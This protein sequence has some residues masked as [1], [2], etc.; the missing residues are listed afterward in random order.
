MSHAYSPE[1]S[2]IALLGFVVV[3]L[4]TSQSFTILLIMSPRPQSPTQPCGQNTNQ[5]FSKNVHETTSVEQESASWFGDEHEESPKADDKLHG[6]PARSA[7]QNIGGSVLSLLVGLLPIYF[8]VFA[9][10]GHDSDGARLLS[11]SQAEWLLK[12]A[13]YVSIATGHLECAFQLTQACQGPTVYPIVFAGIVGSLMTAIASWRLERSISIG[14]LEYLLSSR[15]VGSALLSLLRLRILNTWI[16]LVLMAWCLSPLAGQASLRV[17]DSQLHPRTSTSVVSYLAVN[18]TIITTPNS[19]NYQASTAAAFMTYLTSPS[20]SKNGSQDIYGN[21]QIPMAEAL[22]NAD[23]DDD[24]STV[25]P[26]MQKSAMAGIPLQGIVTGVNSSFGFETSYMSLNCNVNIIPLPQGRDFETAD[27]WYVT[28]TKLGALAGTD[29]VYKPTDGGSGL[30]LIDWNPDHVAISPTPRTIVLQSAW[31]TTNVT[32]AWCRVYTTYVAVTVNCLNGPSDCTVTSVRPSTDPHS[33]ESTTVLDKVGNMNGT[34]SSFTAAAS[35]FEGFVNSVPAASDGGYNAI[36]QYFL[37]PGS[38]LDED[39][40]MPIGAI[41]SE[42][43]SIRFAQ[44]LNTYWLAAS[45]PNAITGKPLEDDMA[46]FLTKSATLETL[47][48]VLRYHAGWGAVLIVV[49]TLLILA[50]AMTSFLGLVRKAPMIL[51]G[52]AGFMRHSPYAEM[53]QN[54]CM[55][56][57]ADIARRLRDQRVQIG[58]VKPEA[59]V[60]MVAVAMPSAWRPVQRLRKGRLYV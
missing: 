11:G 37:K 18:R 20:S 52:F 2:L 23:P 17:V 13:K 47:E 15:S 24:G 33:L 48:V 58:D 50:G 60:G 25:S 5:S 51:D 16:P 40:S 19:T 4:L 49:S 21:L 3:V 1:R 34:G 39:A 54:T 38:P 7:A 30:R 10:L 14:L 57:G 29:K 36:E 6:R 45:A 31:G 55:E 26:Y 27:G 32:E 35:F 43:F 46:P 22:S 12:A 28:S 56:D 41:G 44:L 8:L 9:R 59:E 53:Q 42:L